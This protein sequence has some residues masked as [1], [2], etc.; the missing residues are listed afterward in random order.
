MPDAIPTY[1][2]A[3]TKRV[4][5][6]AIDWP[7]WTRGGRDEDGAMEALAAY[8]PRYRTAM[9]RAA[10]GFRPPADASGLEVVE[11]LKGNA[12]TDFG[13]PAASPKADDRP[14]DDAELRRQSGLLRAAWAALDHAAEAH[15]SA[16]LRTG[17]RGGGRDLP[18][19]V[20]HVAEA[21][22]AYLR[23]L[24]GSF[25][26]DSEADQA[27]VIAG[28]RR[29]VLDT[30][31]SRARGEPPAPSRRTSAP[32]SPRYFVRRATWHVLDHAWEIEDRAGSEPRGSS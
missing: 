21:E 29:A 28:L 8:G 11:R 15:A 26:Y 4:F 6:G 10:R 14:L 2:E 3:G 1:V 24:G 19:I 17:P 9:G 22:G 31:R 25:R 32:W 30:L 5:A 7:G 23:S 12:S 27:A 20:S 18:R 13:A 16:V